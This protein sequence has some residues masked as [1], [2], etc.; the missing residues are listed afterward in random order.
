MKKLKARSYFLLALLLFTTSL[1][2]CDK[3]SKI[4]DT[5][6]EALLFMYEEEKLARDTYDFLNEKWS[7]EQF[8]KIKDSEQ[9]HMDAIGKVLRE[10]D[11]EYSTL[12]KG[13]FS[14]KKLQDHYDQFLIDGKIST[15]HAYQIGA[16]IEDL[17]IVDLLNFE[18]QATND[19]VKNV[20]NKLRCGSRNHIRKFTSDIEYTPQFLTVDE[21]NTITSGENEQC[22]GN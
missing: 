17:D 19:D 16:T 5:D 18:S 4:S 15:E 13:K 2:S 11:I 8:S 21:Y 7:I 3:S 1:S 22:G 6:T 9:K 12:A 10:Y 14:Y 20:F